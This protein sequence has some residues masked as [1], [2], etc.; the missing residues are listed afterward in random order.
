MNRTD[1]MQ[2]VDDY[3]RV[4]RAL[5]FQL[6]IEETQLRSLV[7]FAESRG[8]R[9]PLTGELA[10]A[11]A[12]AS[13]RS[14]P[15]TWSRRLSVV[16]PFA[17]YLHGTDSGTEIPPGRIFGPV[18]RRVPPHVLTKEEVT[19]LV[20]EAGHLFPDKGLRPLTFAALFGLLA[21]TG[22]RVS[23]ALRLQTGDVDL[24]GGLL[25]VRQ[26]KFRKSRLVPLH[27]SAVEA[28]QSY[29]RRRDDLTPLVA[30]SAFFMLGK[31]VPVTWSRTR[32]AVYGVR[33]RLGWQP[34]SSGPQP[35]LRSLRHTFACHRLVAWYEQGADVNNRIH[36][37]STYLGH[38]KVTDTYWYLSGIPELLAIAG[39]RFRGLPGGGGEEP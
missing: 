26:S 9:G 6:R 37:L 28:L 19:Q 22:L 5:G 17:R 18:H 27:P 31:G 4:R 13:R 10:E 34:T 20:Q 16:R 8:H 24:T 14:D 3:L 36:S 38:G 1:L 25:H 33:R 15:Y 30:A 39:K 32:T 29:A 11:W 21:C 7:R 35:C 23:E 12:R 2:A